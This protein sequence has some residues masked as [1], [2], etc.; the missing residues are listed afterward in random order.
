MA[1]RLKGT[2]A[3]ETKNN[4]NKYRRKTKGNIDDAKKSKN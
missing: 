3:R 1:R 2:T 4:K